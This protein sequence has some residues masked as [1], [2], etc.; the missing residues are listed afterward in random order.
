M[1]QPMMNY[2]ELNKIDLISAAEN[3][4]RARRVTALDILSTLR[5]A[6]VIDAKE[7]RSMC[8]QIYSPD[9]ENLTVAEEIIKELLKN[10]LNK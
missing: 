5:L 7:F 6:E 2:G 9:E 1:A 8:K 10:Y 3:R 4:V